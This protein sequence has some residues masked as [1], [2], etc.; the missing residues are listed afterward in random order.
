MSILRFFIMCCFV[1]AATAVSASPEVGDV[2]PDYLGR[3]ENGEK[4]YLSEHKGKVVIVTFWATWC[5]PCLKELP[6][7]E[8]IQRQAG[9]DH[10][11]VIAVNYRQGR[12]A[13]RQIIKKTEDFEITI[14]YDPRDRASN[15]YKIKALPNM[16]IID[17]QGKIAAHHVGYSENSIEGLVAEINRLLMEGQS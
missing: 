10:V 4:I 1:A 6:V 3:D 5:P 12:S 8:G 7:L 11:K 13:Y 16:F 17:R 14:A 9:H 2:P 15:K